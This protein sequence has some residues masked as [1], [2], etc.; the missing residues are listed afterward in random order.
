[1]RSAIGAGD[2]FV[3][4][5]VWALT[6]GHDLK[7]AFRYGVAAGSAALLSEGTGLCHPDDVECYYDAVTLVEPV[8][9]T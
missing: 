6:Q 9:Q 7:Q 1:M 5:M 8:A 3:G 2:S 4:G